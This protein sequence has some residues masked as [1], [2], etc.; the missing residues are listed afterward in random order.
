[1]KLH[2]IVILPTSAVVIALAGI[3][4]ELRFGHDAFARSGS[5]I[6]ILGLAVAGREIYN[7][8]RAIARNEA[9]I[10]K[11][12][13][14]YLDGSANEE[15]A[16]IAGEAFSRLARA[17]SD[18]RQARLDRIGNLI[19]VEMGV[20]CAGTLIWGFGDLFL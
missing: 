20:V 5:L 18:Y 2:P 16:V 6:V 3:F 9:R 13:A 19:Y 14:A 15:G 4:A 12:E 17:L 7:G 8:E 11:L 1:M 10:E